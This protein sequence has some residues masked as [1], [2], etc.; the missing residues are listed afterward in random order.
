MYIVNTSFIVDHAVHDRW[1]DFIK[2]YLPALR[3]QGYG[4]MVFTKAITNDPPGS[5]TYSLQVPVEDMEQFGILTGQVLSECFESIKKMF[6]E[7]VLW[8]ITLLKRVDY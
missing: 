8:F 3:E 1:F 6:G 5:A 7:D 4:E 2:A